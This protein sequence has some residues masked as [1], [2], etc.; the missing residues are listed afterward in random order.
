LSQHEVHCG[1]RETESHRRT[2]ADMGVSCCQSTWLAA[3]EMWDAAAVVTRYYS[4]TQPDS[5]ADRQSWLQL[6][7]Y[8]IY[9]L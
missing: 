2:E 1:L 8:V 5:A 4:G 7:G 6:A 3:G 9:W